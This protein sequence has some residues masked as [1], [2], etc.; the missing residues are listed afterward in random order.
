MA[1]GFVYFN[2]IGVLLLLAVSL[3]VEQWSGFPQGQDPLRFQQQPVLAPQRVQNPLSFQKQPPV[4]APPQAQ[5]PSQFQKQP[6]VLAPPQAQRPSQFQ[7]QPPVL[8]PPQ[9]QRPSQFQKQ[10]PVLVPLQALQS[11]QGAG[12][13]QPQKPAFAPGMLD[14]ASTQ[15]KQLMQA[16]VAPLT[17]QFPHM[18]EE[19]QQPAVPFQL[20][21]PSPPDSV[22]AQC[23][24][25]FVHVEVKKDFY[26]NGHLADPSSFSLGGCAA[27]GEDPNSH[28]LIFQYELHTCGSSLTMTADEFV[29]TFTLLYTPGALV[30]TP[31]VRADAAAIAIH[32]HYPRLHNVSS[33]VLMP[34]AVPFAA[35]I[36]SEEVLVF[37]L[38]LMTD[39]WM[40]ERPVN[41]YFLGQFMNFEASVKQ[42][43]HVPLRVF[44]D[45]CVATAVP[46]VNSV[47]RYSFI[48]NHGCLVDA[49]LTGSPSHFMHRVQN[50]KLQFQ[51]EAFK[52][53]QAGNSSVYVTCALKAV[54]ASTPT[55]LESKACS[56]ANGWTSADESD[57]VCTCCDSICGSTRKGRAVSESGLV[58]EGKA[59]IGPIVISD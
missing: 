2:S 50:N 53:Q 39:D 47:P 29:Y 10:P 56:F 33:D 40:F 59:T 49:K 44:I 13:F 9:A 20:Q 22:A 27:V 41:Q 21:I 23:A 14:P 58:S 45:G 12:S 25:H 51:L 24:E 11:P 15:S 43:N 36:V 31:I 4:L 35:T 42:Y 34:A 17:W 30:G 37:S 38:K 46:D 48:E 6:P 19:P 18:P 26:G 5:R 7:K 16:P 1:M 8:A 54:L 3:S 32:C 57:D 28:V 52:F 55:N